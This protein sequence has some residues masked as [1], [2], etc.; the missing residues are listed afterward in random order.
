MIMSYT[1]PI[2]KDEMVC[3]RTNVTSSFK[4]ANQICRKVN[5]KKFKVAK[6]FVN[7][8][9][10]EKV[11]VNGKYHTK[12]ANH[13]QNLLKGLEMNAS[14]RNFTADDMVLFISAHKG[15]KIYRSRRKRRFGLRLKNCNIHAVLKKVK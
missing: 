7:N 9:V 14:V 10:E 12:V 8:L 11:T 5:R 15:R 3:A 4:A 6:K 1:F 2:K 13:I